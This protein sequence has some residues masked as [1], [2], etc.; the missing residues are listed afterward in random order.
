MKMEENVFHNKLALSTQLI[1]FNSDIH[2]TYL[3]YLNSRGK[4]LNI[5]ERKKI[6]VDTKR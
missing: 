1:E 2:I 3:F 6:S 4:N 5:G